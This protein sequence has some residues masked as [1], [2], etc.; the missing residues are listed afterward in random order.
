VEE[1]FTK[2][3]NNAEVYWCYI[4]VP[5][6]KRDIFPEMNTKFKIVFQGQSFDV[7]LNKAGRINSRALVERLCETETF[8]IT[9]IKKNDR[10]FQLLKTINFHK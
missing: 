10:E 2:E 4:Q 5:H 7:A 1:G 8:T 9:F 6:D 3:L